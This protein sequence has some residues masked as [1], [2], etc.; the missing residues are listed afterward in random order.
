MSVYISGL[1]TTVN[2]PD[3]PMKLLL[4]GAF[5]DESSLRYIKFLFSEKPNSE[6]PILQR[7][8]IQIIL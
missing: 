1:L 3:Y 4:P 5:F 2:A 7:K 8:T 6:N